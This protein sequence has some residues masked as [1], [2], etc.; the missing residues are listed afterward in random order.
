MTSLGFHYSPLVKWKSHTFQEVVSTLQKNT[1]TSTQTK[2]FFRATPLKHY[3]RNIGRTNDSEALISSNTERQSVTIATV[4]E[5]PGGAV[6]TTVPICLNN[7]VGI[8]MDQNITYNTYEKGLCSTVCVS[9]PSNALK[10]V[11]SAGMIRSRAYNVNSYQYL[12][13]V[14]RRDS[15]IPSPL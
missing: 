13:C 4:M 1:N 11:K 7:G 5:Q 15:T 3:R 10:R 6:N 9:Q 2:S 8:T 14:N 12:D